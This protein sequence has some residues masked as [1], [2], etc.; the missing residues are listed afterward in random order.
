VGTS[1]VAN[2]VDAGTPTTC[3]AG[4]HLVGTSCLPNAVDAGTPTTCGTGTYLS[5][6]KC[7]PITNDAGI[8]CGPGTML[9][10]TQCVPAATTGGPTFQV[11]VN[12]TTIG[13]D[14][15]T[16]IPV[17]L[18]GT[19]PD[20][21]PNTD[22]VVIDTSRGGAG[23]VSPNTITLDPLGSTVYFT[24][25]SSAA[26]KFCVGPA[27]ITLA[28]ASA[29][30][31]ILAE[32]QEL[33]LVALPDVGS[34][35]PCLVGGDVLFLDG[36]PGDYIFAG[37]ETITQGTWTW[38]GSQSEVHIAVTPSDT[39]QGFWW[40]LYFDSSLLNNPTLVDQV[41]QNAQGWPYE[42]PGHPGLGVSGYGVGCYA[43]AGQFQIEDIRW[44]NS[45]LLTSFTATFEHHCDGSTAALRGCVHYGP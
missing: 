35:A 8:T 6:G 40:N 30:N 19:N 34:D 39:S 11:R 13:A 21:T 36:D 24:P 17:L 3:G 7:L 42:T 28:E 29:P 43:A 1:C 18:F 23:F 41:Y 16:M 27:Y 12:V 15:N 14:G 45:G 33:N 38:D 31:T 22:T 2:A 26:S 20:G 10:G 4:T 44:S 25:C 37:M 32:S 5:G 9:S